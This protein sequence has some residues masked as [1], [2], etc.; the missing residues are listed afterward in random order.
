MSF[1]VSYMLLVRMSHYTCR[2]EMVTDVQGNV[3]WVLLEFEFTEMRRWL[4]RLA[5]SCDG[6]K[7]KIFK[8]YLLSPLYASKQFVMRE[9]MSMKIDK[10]ATFETKF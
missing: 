2:A 9:N 4:Y 1:I 6:N 10:Q 8:T 3:Y 5:C 7:N